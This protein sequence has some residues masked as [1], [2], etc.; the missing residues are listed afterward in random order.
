MSYQSA[1][2]PLKSKT[3]SKIPIWWRSCKNQMGVRN[4]RRY[5][6]QRTTI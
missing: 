6:L 2:P 1:Q 5:C 3:H 4:L